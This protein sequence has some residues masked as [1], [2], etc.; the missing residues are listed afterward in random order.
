MT[1][2]VW[3]VFGR[4]ARHVAGL[5]TIRYRS[6]PGLLLLG[7]S[8]W[9]P[10][11]AFSAEAACT[12]LRVTLTTCALLPPVSK[13]MPGAVYLFAATD[14]WFPLGHA[15]RPPPPDVFTKELAFSHC[16]KAEC[17][18]AVSSGIQPDHHRGHIAR[19]REGHGLCHLTH[20]REPRRRRRRHLRRRGGWYWPGLAWPGQQRLP[21]RP[22]PVVH[23]HL[24]TRPLPATPLPP[25]ASRRCARSWA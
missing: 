3:L 2:L 7:S 23:A 25:R 22:A 10:A 11:A 15:P 20:Q 9:A 18:P 13:Q 19:R 6:S 17:L 24:A 5:G 14:C 16:W 12:Y 1:C 21:A 8:S 4:R